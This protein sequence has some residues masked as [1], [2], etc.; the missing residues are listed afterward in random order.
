MLDYSE[1]KKFFADKL[2]GDADGIGRFESAFY[3]TMR[4]VYERGVS[5][6]EAGKSGID[7]GRVAEDG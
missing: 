4:M 6:G 2:A 5:D 3:W 7:E 1:V